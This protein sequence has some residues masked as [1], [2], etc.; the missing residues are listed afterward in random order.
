MFGNGYNSDNRKAVLY[1]VRLAD[2]VLLKKIDTLQGNST[3]PNGLATPSLIADGTRT[4]RAIYA[5]DL[6]GNMWKFDVSDANPANWGSAYKDVSNNPVPLYIAKDSGG[7][8]QPITA[9][10]QV[11]RH[12]QG[13]YMI[14]FGTGKFFV[15]GDNDVVTTTPQIQTF[16]ALWDKA[17][18]P[19]AITDR[20]ALQ[21]Q[22]ILFEASPRTAS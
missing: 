3:T 22:Q 4:I 16:Y 1:I 8:R 15:N 13:G 20:S 14:Y 2:G 6:L 10:A 18:S 12:P 9:Q 7:A 17:V 19:S 11:G 21:Q 5:G